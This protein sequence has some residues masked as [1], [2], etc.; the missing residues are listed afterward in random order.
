MRSEVESRNAPKLPALGPNFRASAPSSASRG[1][2]TK[3]AI[4][5][6]LT[7]EPG[8]TPLGRKL[9]YWLKQSE[10]TDISPLTELLLFNAS[11]TQL[12]EKVIKPGLEKGKIVICDRYADS[13]LPT[14]ATAGDWI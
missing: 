9:R 12:V 6:I 2:K 14:R 1:T 5:A 4:P 10:D 13:T 8:G 3:M 7:H 11:R